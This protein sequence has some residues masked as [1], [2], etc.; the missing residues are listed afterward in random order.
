MPDI[1]CRHRTETSQSKRLPH[2]H[3]TFQPCAAQG[4]IRTSQPANTT[5]HVSD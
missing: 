2:R 4:G 3:V 5:R 1:W